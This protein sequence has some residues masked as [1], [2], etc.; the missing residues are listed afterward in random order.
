M[1]ARRGALAAASL[2]AAVALA[3]ALVA[4]QHSR[5]GPQVCLA[6]ALFCD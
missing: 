3:G 4:V 6:R 1:R 5:Y 2:A